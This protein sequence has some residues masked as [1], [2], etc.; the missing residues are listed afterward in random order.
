[1]FTYDDNI[2]SDLHKDARGFRPRGHE[3]FTATP[4][5]KQQIWE[6]LCDELEASIDAEAR[7]HE[8]AEA[9][10]D[11]Q[12]DQALALGAQDRAQAIR[13]IAQ[14]MDEADA[15]YICFLLGLSYD[16]EPEIA[17]AIEG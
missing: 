17:A 13:W 10:L 14:G 1:M 3:Y 8:E 4:A 7:A 15:G 6:V 12:V 9:D 2:F 5:R 16:L 11:R